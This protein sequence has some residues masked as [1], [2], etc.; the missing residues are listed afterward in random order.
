MHHFHRS[1]KVFFLLSFRKHDPLFSI[2]LH[3]T[4]RQAKI[5]LHGLHNYGSTVRVFKKEKP[6]KS[7]KSKLKLKKTIHSMS[8]N[9]TADSPGL[10]AY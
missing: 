6:T 3:I 7:L 4:Q 2:F 1:K 9:L 8:H 5:V 10:F